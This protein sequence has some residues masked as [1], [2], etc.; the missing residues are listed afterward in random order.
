[1]GLDLVELVIETEER[2][3]IEIDD[4][5]AQYLGTVG[6]LARYVSDKTLGQEKEYSYEEAT[7]IVIEMLVK[8]YGIPEGKANSTSHFVDDLRL[9]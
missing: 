9:D 6:E 5:D 8:N 4:E 7:R 3:D 1:M 2:F